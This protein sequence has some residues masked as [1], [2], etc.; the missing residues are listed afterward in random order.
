MLCLPFE[1]SSILN[2][3]CVGMKKTE[4]RIWIQDFVCYPTFEYL[5]G[6]KWRIQNT[7]PHIADFCQAI[8]QDQIK[9]YETFQNL[10]TFDQMLEQKKYKRV[11]NLLTKKVSISVAPLFWHH[12]DYPIT[13]SN[14]FYNNATSRIFR[15]SWDFFVSI[16]SIR[17][18]LLDI[19]LWMEM[20][21][22]LLWNSRLIWEIEFWIS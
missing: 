15:D 1:I 13:T 9:L 12:Q 21:F 11:K 5:I 8:Y 16:D 4:V 20:G 10:A 19:S 2:L 14:M 17:K 3:F 7:P 18:W 22:L 6:E